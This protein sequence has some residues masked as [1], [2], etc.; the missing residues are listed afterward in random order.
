ME[1]KNYQLGQF[2]WADYATEQAEALKEF[3]KEVAGWKEHPIAMKDD[4]G[5]YQDY[6]MLTAD[7]EAA[8]GVCHRRGV[9]SK[10]PSQWIM[11]IYAPD[12]DERLEKVLALG[13]KFIHGS[14][15]KDDKYSFVIVED[16]AGAVFG[17]GRME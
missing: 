13:G 12:V 6:A 3:Y 1:K 11:Y 16:P 8:G 2:V 10:I 5:D 4:A 9:N 17:I 14:K 7:N 15:G